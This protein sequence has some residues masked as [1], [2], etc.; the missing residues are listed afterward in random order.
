MDLPIHWWLLANPSAHSPGFYCP[1]LLCGGVLPHPFLSLLPQSLCNV[2]VQLGCPGVTTRLGGAEH[3]A[4]G[5]QVLLWLGAVRIST[6][7]AT[8]ALFRHGVNQFCTGTSSCHYW[9]LADWNNP[10]VHGGEL[11]PLRSGTFYL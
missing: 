10:C 11:V 9:D 4:L 8:P 2:K 7:R 3:T 1:I 5:V 6:T